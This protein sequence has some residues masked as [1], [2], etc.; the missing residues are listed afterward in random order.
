[1]K[2][3]KLTKCVNNAAYDLYLTSIANAADV[4]GNTASRKF[5]AA[6]LRLQR[7]MFGLQSYWDIDRFAHNAAN[8][9][10][11]ALSA[12]AASVS[13]FASTATAAVVQHANVS[14]VCLQCRCSKRR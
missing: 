6:G 9:R 4:V 5:H 14:H 8:S 1:M 7:M 12:E 13:A 3:A 11:R 10:I 2:V